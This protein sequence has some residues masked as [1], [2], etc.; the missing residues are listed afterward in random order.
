LSS[1]FNDR[2]S[3][4]RGV[5]QCDRLYW[6]VMF[7]GT[8]LLWREGQEIPQKIIHRDAAVL[9]LCNLHENEHRRRRG[10]VVR[11][12]WGGSEEMHL[13]WGA[14]RNT[15]KFGSSVTFQER[16]QAENRCYSSCVLQCVRCRVHGS[17]RTTN[18]V[19]TLHISTLRLRII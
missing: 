5:L 8:V 2:H 18:Y 13:Q 4:L 19:S 12:T 1:L 14:S 6:N 9:Q 3:W 7:W 17:F 15:F 16:I 10:H 11:V